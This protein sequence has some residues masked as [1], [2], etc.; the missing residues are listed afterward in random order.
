M[1]HLKLLLTLVALVLF[2]ACQDDSTS[3]SDED[4]DIEAKPGR[5]FP[6]Q[7]GVE[8]EYEIEE[9]GSTYK[10]IST[11]NGETQID[12]KTWIEQKS[13]TGFQSG[14][15]H[16]RYEDGKYYQFLPS[17]TGV[18]IEDLN[19]MLL[20]ENAEVGTEWELPHNVKFQASS[21]PI[22]AIYTSEIKEKL[23]SY[24]VKGETYND[25]VAVSTNLSYII[26]G[27]PFSRIDQVTYF[28][29]DV[30]VIKVVGFQTGVSFSQS[31]IK[32]IP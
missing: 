21:S 20:D 12:G 25:V 28:A 17:G 18:I 16:Y 15:S 1:R 23:D 19:F 27:A 10:L 26:D 11:N 32:Y 9:Q 31:L 7:L 4:V 30:G 5:Y 13:V 3:P 14:N 22:D 29:A 6:L 24:E 8:W 2:T